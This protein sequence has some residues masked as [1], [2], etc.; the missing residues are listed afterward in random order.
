MPA[1]PSQL[2]RQ[3]LVDRTIDFG[4]GVTVTFRFDRNK[5]TDAFV[6]QWT[7]FETDK[8]TEAINSVLEGLIVSWDVVNDDGTPYPPTAENIGFL[9]TLVDKGR[10]VS[11]LLEASV[12]S[13][14]E[15]NASSEPSSIPPSVFTEPQLTSPNGP[16]PSPSLQPSASQSTT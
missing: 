16:A 5:M 4:D 13:R 14:A 7:Q 12:P 1:T 3:I 6:K 11:D 9:F 15:G 8:N 10:I 2:R